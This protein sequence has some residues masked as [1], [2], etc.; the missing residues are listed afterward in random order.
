V[1]DSKAQGSSQAFAR[2]LRRVTPH[3]SKKEQTEMDEM[4]CFRYFQL[5]PCP[6]L[7]YLALLTDGDHFWMMEVIDSSSSL[8][9][10]CV[11]FSFTKKISFP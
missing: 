2:T 7:H 11:G 8:F 9:L 6:I 5:A 10:D 1:R 4:C 3:V